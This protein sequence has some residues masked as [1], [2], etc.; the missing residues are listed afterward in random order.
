MGTL[1]EKTR[2]TAVVDF[3][4]IRNLRGVPGLEFDEVSGCDLHG[5]LACN[6]SRGR[7]L[8]S[9]FS[10]RSVS[11]KSIET[12]SGLSDEESENGD[13]ADFWF[14]VQHSHLRARN[15]PFDE[16]QFAASADVVW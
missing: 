9:G 4:R 10:E 16:L 14:S 11:T 6:G 15:A 13:F 8:R 7:K 2:Q 5:I 3:R 12:R 1:G